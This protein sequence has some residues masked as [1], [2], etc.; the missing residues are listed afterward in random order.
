[1]GGM[2]EGERGAGAARASERRKKIEKDERG[3]S[4]DCHDN[5]SVPIAECLQSG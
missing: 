3:W 4:P 2:G 1:M 5:G